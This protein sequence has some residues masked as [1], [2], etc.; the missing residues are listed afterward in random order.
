LA[1]GE[2]GGSAGRGGGVGLAT[3]VGAGVGAASGSLGAGGGVTGAATMAAGGLGN[4]AA[5]AAALAGCLMVTTEPKAKPV[6][7]AVT[8]QTARIGVNRGIGLL[9]LGAF[10]HDPERILCR[11]D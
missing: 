8:P 11:P 10:A 3:G 2:A 9:L 4:F 5:G 1:A 6:T 7:T